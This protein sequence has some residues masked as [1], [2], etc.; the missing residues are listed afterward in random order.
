[1]LAYPTRL[2]PG[3]GFNLP[4]FFTLPGLSTSGEDFRIEIRLVPG[5]E[6]LTGPLR[7]EPR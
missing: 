1:M 3:Q 2:E 4:L 5:R 6:V 7:V